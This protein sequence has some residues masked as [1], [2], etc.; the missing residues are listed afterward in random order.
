MNLIQEPSPEASPDFN[1]EASPDYSLGSTLDSTQDSV[2][3][4]ITIDPTYALFSKIA[5]S[6]NIQFYGLNGGSGGLTIEELHKIF[7]SYGLYQGN[8]TSSGI[9]NTNTHLTLARALM[10]G[11]FGIGTAFS[12]YQCFNVITNEEIIFWATQAILFT[13]SASLLLFYYRSVTPVID[14]DALKFSNTYFFT[15]L[16]HTYLI[17]ILTDS[18]KESDNKYTLFKCES[19]KTLKDGTREPTPPSCGISYQEIMS[20]FLTWVFKN[21]LELVTVSVPLS[22]LPPNIRSK[23]SQT[24]DSS[25]DYSPDIDNETII[26]NLDD[27]KYSS[28]TDFLLTNDD[29]LFNPF[30]SR[31]PFVIDLSPNVTLKGEITDE[32]RQNTIINAPQ[33]PT[34]IRTKESELSP[35]PSIQESELT[36][37]PSIQESFGDIT[38]PDSDISKFCEKEGKANMAC[39]CYYQ[40]RDIMNTW[41]IAANNVQKNND[42]LLADWKK[43]HNQWQADSAAYR[44][45]ISDAQSVLSKWTGKGCIDGNTECCRNAPNQQTSVHIQYWCNDHTEK[46]GSI[47]TTLT[48]MH[49]KDSWPVINILGKKYQVYS[50]NKGDTQIYYNVSSN[51]KRV[52]TWSPGWCGIDPKGSG[53]ATDH[54]G[55]AIDVKFTKNGIKNAVKILDAKIK[56]KLIYDEPSKPPYLDLP[57]IDAAINCCINNIQNITGKNIRQSCDQSITKQII[58]SGGFSPSGGDS[59]SGSGGDSGGDS[60]DDNS[61]K[62]NNTTLLIVG[63]T[64][65][66]VIIIALLLYFF[67]F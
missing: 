10:S 31:F 46:P 45:A 49:G 59:G 57:K 23:F 13:V 14:D 24:P 40:T 61:D 55:C 16:Y 34:Q 42:Q 66:I 25:P 43:R 58:D 67:A 26:I 52:P 35:S 7:N 29:F 30:S 12:I 5:R 53:D 20:Y 41:E 28:I 54:E 47:G 18:L 64:V 37:S 27:P 2:K 4:T 44:K 62:S 21:K 11:I 51:P 56:P 60:G 48:K 22:L 6:I 32:I 8:V 17:D 36:P 15:P 65:P 1:P 63:I 19:I 33:P 3:S 38:P 9:K 50:N 39:G